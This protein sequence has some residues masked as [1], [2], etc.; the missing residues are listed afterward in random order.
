MEGR[1]GLPKRAGFGNSRSSHQ[2]KQENGGED[3]IYHDYSLNPLF[4]FIYSSLSV[5]TQYG[6]QYGNAI[7][8][9]PSRR[10]HGG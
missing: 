9:P 8:N 4:L 6:K 1:D 2:Q 3:G 7:Y 10:E 5:S